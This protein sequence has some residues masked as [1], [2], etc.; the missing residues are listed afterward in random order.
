[1][2][3]GSSFLICSEDN[4]RGTASTV[5]D[6]AGKSKASTRPPEELEG[7][8]ALLDQVQLVGAPVIDVLPFKR[9]PLGPAFGGQVQAEGKDVAPPPSGPRVERVDFRALGDTSFLDEFIAEIR[10]GRH[11]ANHEGDAPVEDAEQNGERSGSRTLKTPDEWHSQGKTPS[12][13]PPGSFSKEPSEAEETDNAQLRSL[14]SRLGSEDVTEDDNAEPKIGMLRSSASG[15]GGVLLPPLGLPADPVLLQEQSQPTPKSAIPATPRVDDLPAIGDLGSRRP[16]TE[17]KRWIEAAVRRMFSLLAPAALESLIESFREWKLPK[18][19]VIVKQATPISTG[20]GL[21]VLLDGV[22][23]VM[24]CPKGAKESDKVCTYDRCGQ[25]FGE[26][27]LFCD[28]SQMTPRS[29][30]RKLH[31]ATVATRTPVTLW[32][33][34]RKALQQTS[35]QKENLVNNR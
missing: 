10:S 29:S 19:V 9:S 30:G 3:N 8:G 6:S 26:L 12:L 5:E 4:R 14:V 31:W 1:M 35:M 27:E 18:G 28:G 2:G 25:C 24:H 11:A 21:C 34:D 17:E 13:P 33:V 23:D 32:I 16:G 20:P 15:R 22:V 7:S